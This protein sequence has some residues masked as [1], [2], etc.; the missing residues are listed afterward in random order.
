MRPENLILRCYGYRTS[1]GTWALK[2]IDL[3]IAEEEDTLPK[4]KQALEDAIRS[5]IEA[6]MDTDDKSSIS[7]L[8]T[9]KSCVQDRIRYNAFSVLNKIHEFKSR[10]AFNET[11]PFHIS[12]S[13]SA[14]C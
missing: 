5:Y 9:R 14:C 8:L 13:G 7:A 2:C 6:V 12:G 10:F 3:N 11:I 4:A 1:H